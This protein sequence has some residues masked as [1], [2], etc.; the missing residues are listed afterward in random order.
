LL[1]YTPPVAGHPDTNA[2][3]VLLPPDVPEQAVTQ[4]CLEE[5]ILRNKFGFQQ[6]D[7]IRSDILRAVDWAE[8]AWCRR[9][10]LLY[11]QR[12]DATKSVSLAGRITGGCHRLTS[13][14]MSTAD[15]KS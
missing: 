3:A 2:T 11:A 15:P 8:D 7:P 1:S 10:R 14:A 13:R 5:I 12:K 4:V 9:A 6:L